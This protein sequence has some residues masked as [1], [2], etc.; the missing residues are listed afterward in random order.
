[1][2]EYGSGNIPAGQ[3][4]F[5]GSVPEDLRVPWGLRDLFVFVFS[6]FVGLILA[7]TIV[8]SIAY[9]VFHVPLKEITGATDTTARSL[10]VT[11]TQAVWSLFVLL[12]FFVLVRARSHSRFWR[13][14][15]WRPFPQ[16]EQ[17]GFAPVLL[18]LGTGAILAIFA[19]FAGRF[20]GQQ[21]ELPIEQMFRSR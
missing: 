4:P 13:A 9:A 6:G 10:I 11:L 20:V 17:S 18:Y 21:Q 7:G 3:F 1:S 14:I 8:G 16:S 19:S 15:G 5:R 2:G 12:Y